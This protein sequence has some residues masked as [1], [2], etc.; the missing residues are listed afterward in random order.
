MSETRRLDLRNEFPPVSNRQWE[1]VIKKDL[2]GADYDRKLLWQTDDGITVKPYYRA[3][4]VEQFHANA[5]PGT[6]P[7]V[8]GT[9]TSPGWRIR[10][11]ITEADPKKANELARKALESGADEICFVIESAVDGLSG[12][13]ATT[14]PEMS[15][16]LSR[17][18]LDLVSVQFRAGSKASQVYE[19]L[20]QG[21]GPRA[22]HLNGSIDHDPLGDLALTG[23]SAIGKNA[24]FDRAAELVG[25]A[26]KR[27]PSMLA[28]T[29][30]AWEFHEAGGTTLQELGY[31][32]AQAIEYVSELTSRG[33]GA[34]QVASSLFFCYAVGTNYFFEIAKLRAARQL[35]ARALSEFGIPEDA[36]ASTVHVRTSTWGNTIYDPYVNVLRGTTEAMS[37]AIGGCDSLSVA[38]FDECYKSADEFSRRLARNTQIILKKETYLDNIID[39]AAGSY[40]VET[41]TASIANEA[42]KI[43]QQVESCGG[44]LKCLQEGCIQE[45][46]MESR[47]AK[48]AAIAARRRNLLGTN[49]FPDQQERVLLQVQHL[50]ARFVR[51]GPAEIRVQ[52][53]VPYRAAEAF[54]A[55]RL[56]MERHTARTGRTPTVMM[57]EIGD[58]K[59]RKARSTFSANLFACGG[60]Q[61]LEVT[62]DDIEAAT[63]QAIEVDPDIV[64]LC[65]SDQEYP[66]LASPFIRK[67]RDQGKGCPVV[68]AGYPKDMIDKLR[69][70]GAA[71]FIHIKSNA[72][73]VIK[74]W[75]QRLGVGE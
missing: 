2:K 16:L 48:D 23:A 8:R 27:T 65:S 68:V 29:V 20:V 19:N 1:E 57:V 54:E 52:P 60:F 11:D 36:A 47:R 21:V 59:M 25:S 67:L 61:I 32:L 39:P 72:L 17:I 37:A 5:A 9:T 49:Q 12:I 28:L 24:M 3:E 30:R 73:D 4:D 33:L 10:E 50:S 15:V 6:F 22:L 46:I 51:G 64:V 56:R 31:S 63:T 18:P 34:A 40:Y 71:D 42:W 35:W 7:F 43:M 75:Q 45:G 70:D 69:E 74:T 53:L 62:A 14:P 26:R 58:L 55:L 38:A 66:Q 13:R 44:F 41:L